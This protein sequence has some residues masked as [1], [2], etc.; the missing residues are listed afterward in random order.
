MLYLCD[1]GIFHSVRVAVRILI[2]SDSQAALKAL[3][4]PEVTSGLVA[5]CLNALSAL[6]SLNRVTLAWVPGHRGISSNEEV[7]RIVQGLDHALLIV[8]GCAM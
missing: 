6:A 5:E 7:D 3:G 4:G 2:F 8:V 1:T